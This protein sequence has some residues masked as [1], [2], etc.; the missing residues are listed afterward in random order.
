MI[1]DVCEKSLAMP[2]LSDDDGYSMLLSAANEPLIPTRKIPKSAIAIKSCTLRGARRRLKL[3]PPLANQAIRAMIA[4][5]V[6]VLIKCAPIQNGL[7]GVQR[8]SIGLDR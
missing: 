8:P 4:I 1:C 6:K 2:S 7:A 5:K 3:F